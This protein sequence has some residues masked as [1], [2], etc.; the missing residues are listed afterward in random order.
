ME[1]RKNV[2]IFGATGNTG[3]CA[4]AHALEAGDKVHVFVRNAKKLADEIKSQVHVIVGDLTDPKAVAKAV[5]QSS[6]DAILVC[7]GHPPRDA[8]APMNEVAVKAIEKALTESNRL[9]ACFVIYLSGLFTDPYYDPLPWSLKLMRAIVV[10][11]FGYQ[12]SLRDNMAVTEYLT[13][14]SGSNSGLQYTIIRMA[15]PVK[16]NSRGSIVP[17]AGNPKGA[18]TFTDMGHF[19]VRLAHGEYRREAIG[20]AIKPSYAE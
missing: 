3:A 12:A 15:L 7:S 18:V 9:K 16:G 6:P 13:R 19:M 1:I 4:V 17:V 5:Q 20:K 14:G 8:I 10:P 2:L 11:M